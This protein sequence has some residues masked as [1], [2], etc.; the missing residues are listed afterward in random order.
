[1]VTG[2]ACVQ[3]LI[4]SCRELD[5][6]GFKLADEL[7]SHWQ[8]GGDGQVPSFYSRRKVSDK[9]ILRYVLESALTVGSHAP[10]HLNVGVFQLPFV[11]EITEGP[12]DPCSGD[13]QRP[14]L[15]DGRCRGSG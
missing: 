10:G 15:S 6:E 11:Q 5:P 9:D 4:T 3:N 14:P 8:V 12:A 2:A 13:G 7:R 1:M